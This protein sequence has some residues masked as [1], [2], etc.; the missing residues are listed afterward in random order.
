MDERAEALVAST[1]DHLGNPSLSVAEIEAAVLAL[2]DRDVMLARRLIDVVPEGFGLVLISHIQGAD[3]M[4]LPTT[5]SVQNAAGDWVEFPLQR[6][7]IFVAA[8]LA[9]QQMFHT[10]PRLQFQ[11]VTDRSALLNT[12]NNALNEGGSLEGSSLGGP[13]FLGI[14]AAIYAEGLPAA[15]ASTT[16]Q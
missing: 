12:V 6:E 1:I 13:S 11:T 10:G 16:R 14:P 15:V 5:F 4:Q 7:P 8:V 9:A 3:G 2:A